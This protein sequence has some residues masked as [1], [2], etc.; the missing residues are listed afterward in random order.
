VIPG[1]PIPST[2]ESSLQA[3]AVCNQPASTHFNHNI[4]N[5]YPRIIYTQRLKMAP[6]A[7][8]GIAAGMISCYCNRCHCRW[9]V[10]TPHLSI[11]FAAKNMDI[12]NLSVLNGSTKHWNTCNQSTL[13]G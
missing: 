7:L 10:L 11:Q 8:G 13:H 4:Y 9:S 2:V 6:L 3:L 12:P 5:I 1:L